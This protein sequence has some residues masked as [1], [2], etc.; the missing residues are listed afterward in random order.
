MNIT[1]MFLT[2]GLCAAIFASCSTGPAP[3]L[4]YE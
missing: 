3:R 2:V 4:V 1:S